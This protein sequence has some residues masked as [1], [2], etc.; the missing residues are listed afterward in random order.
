MFIYQ[1]FCIKS[2]EIFG[3]CVVQKFLIIRDSS[4]NPRADAKLFNLLF[5]I[6]EGL[7]ELR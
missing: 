2:F 3:I 5:P 7:I 1:K 6:H 4:S